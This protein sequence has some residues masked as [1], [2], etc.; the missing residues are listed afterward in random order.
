MPTIDTTGVVLLTKE[1]DYPD[2]FNGPAMVGAI[3]SFYVDKA[4]L[5]PRLQYLYAKR[6]IC[7]LIL[8]QVWQDVTCSEGGAQQSDG[9]LSDHMQ[10]L[11]DSL[12]AELLLLEK[13]IAA[14]RGGA[15][16]LMTAT[17]PI[18]PGP[19]QPDPNGRVYRGDPLQ[20]R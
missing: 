16:G 18:R 17:A 11:Y 19:Q 5:A 8:Q 13:R 7:Q 20:R 12:T 2:G 1:F 3:W 15:M 14:N 9:Q 6:H 4:P 10:K